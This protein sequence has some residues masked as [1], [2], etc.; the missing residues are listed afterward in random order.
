MWISG[1]N[2]KDK[3]KELTFVVW[4]PRLSALIVLP[5]FN[6]PDNARRYLLHLT[7]E[8]T[9]A[10]KGGSKRGAGQRSQAGWPDSGQVLTNPG[11]QVWI[12]TLLLCSGGHKEV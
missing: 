7:A 4:T 2:Q 12:Q 3:R 1:F 5:L 8:D 10:K 6:N 9:E 11:T